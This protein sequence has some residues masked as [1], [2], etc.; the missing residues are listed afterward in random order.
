MSGPPSSVLTC[1]AKFGSQLKLLYY[2][3]ELWVSY[4]ASQ[5]V[6]FLVVNETNNNYN[7]ADF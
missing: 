6:N 4:P 7:F 1:D 3:R 2:L 5:N